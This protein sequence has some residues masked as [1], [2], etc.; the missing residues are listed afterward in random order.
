MNK[1]L[2]LLFFRKGES[3]FLKE[4]SKELL[5]IACVLLALIAPAHANDKLTVLLDWFVN[6]NHGP[7]IVAQAIGAFQRQGLDVEFVEPADPSMPP[8]LVAAGRGDIAIGYQPQLYQQVAQG[9]QLARIGVLI[10]RPMETLETLEPSGIKTIGDLKGKRVGYNNVG[11]D[12]NL[13]DIAQML[14]TAGL[15]L[16]DVTLVNIGTALTTSLL[17]GQVDAVGVDRNFETFELIEHGA[18]PRGFDYEA[19]GVPDFDYLIMIVQKSRAHDPAMVRF[20]RA[21]QEGGAYIRAHPDQAWAD[22]V[23]LYPNDDNALNLSAWRF[24]IGCFAVDP[25]SLDVKK[26]D[27]FADFL[28]ARGVIPVALPVGAYAVALK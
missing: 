2:L 12:V 23:K 13:A 21:V 15:K 14:S 22:F 4:R 11:G 8:L 1:S 27:R 5:S 24:T 25:F 17:T 28:R 10:D 20:L 16:T 26:Y 9:L 3:S 6:P 19:Y 7:L 18:K